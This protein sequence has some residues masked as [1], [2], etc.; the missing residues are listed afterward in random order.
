MLARY[1]KTMARGAAVTLAAA[2]L[3]ALTAFGAQAQTIYFN[4]DNTMPSTDFGSTCTTNYYVD[5]Y[6]NV[7]SYMSCSPSYTIYYAPGY[8][9]YFYNP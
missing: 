2:A 8:D 5:S 1:R 7:G 4:L 3:I 6:G 9:Y